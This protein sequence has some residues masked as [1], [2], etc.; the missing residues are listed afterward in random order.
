MAGYG[1]EE[2]SVPGGK[3]LV[4]RLNRATSEE[5]RGPHPAA[6]E[7]PF[8]P[9][10]GAGQG[11]DDDGRGPFGRRGEEPGDM[12]FVV[13]FQEAQEASLVGEV[14]AEMVPGGGGVA[15]HDAIVETYVVTEVETLL[16]QL[17]F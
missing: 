10:R 13:V 4:E 14:G 2:R 16:L 12:R 17:P 3:L 9:Q 11:G 6:F 8:V 5:D 15:G 7:L 1:A